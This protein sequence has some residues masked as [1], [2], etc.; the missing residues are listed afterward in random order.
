MS[1][2]SVTGTRSFPGVGLLRFQGRVDQL[3]AGRVELAPKACE[4]MR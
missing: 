1:V 4:S 3:H 2:S